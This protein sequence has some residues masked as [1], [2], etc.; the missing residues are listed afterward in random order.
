MANNN[1]NPSPDAATRARRGSFTTQ[2][3]NNIF[4]RSN[5]TSGGP[6]GPITSA[7]AQDQRRRMSIS[8]LGLSGSSPTQTTPFTFGPRRGSVS[9]ERSDS[10]D[11]SAIDDDDGPSRSVPTTPFARRMSFGAQALRA[12]TTGG[13]PGANGRSSP[14]TT[15]PKTNT[16]L[17]TIPAGPRGGG[18][19][20]PKSQASQA[21]T[22]SKPRTASD[23][24]VSARPG[25]G[26]GFNWSEQLR[27]RAESSVSQTQRP[28]F[29][30]SPT[31]SKITHDR[32]KSVSEMPTPPVAVPP[33]APV[34]PARKQP[35]AFQERILKGDFYMD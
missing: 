14:Y 28:S 29:S 20:P 17:P 3:F 34:R 5:S 9:T 32:T 6:S 13:S 1:D 25:E 31:S 10:I 24:P 23:Y 11:E 35:D 27:S 18:V 2:T 26:S 16:T 8:T 22:Q 19:T 12:R 7:A 33:P 30:T 15:A 21:S 4:G